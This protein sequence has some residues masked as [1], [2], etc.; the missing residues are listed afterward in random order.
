MQENDKHEFDTI[1]PAQGAQAQQKDV[2]LTLL[3]SLTSVL[4]SDVKM[5]S[6]NNTA[7]TTAS[8]PETTM[9]TTNNDDA[10]LL[11]VP[12]QPEAPTNSKVEEETTLAN[13]PA[14]TITTPS[15]QQEAAPESNNIIWMQQWTPKDVVPTETPNE[16]TTTTTNEEKEPQAKPETIVEAQ[17]QQL[18]AETTTTTTTTTMVDTIPQQPEDTTPQLTLVP[19]ITAEILTD[20]NFLEH[21][22]FTFFLN[23]FYGNDSR[24]VKLLKMCDQGCVVSYLSR[25]GELLAKQIPGYRTKDVRGSWNIFIKK[26]PNAYSFTHR[27][28]EHCVKTIDNVFLLTTFGFEWE[29]E[30][31]FDSLAMNHID[32]FETRLL[33]LD[34]TVTSPQLKNRPNFAQEMESEEAQFRQI[35]GSPKLRNC[36]VH[37]NPKKSTFYQCCVIYFS[38]EKHE[39]TDEE[40][41]GLITSAKSTANMQAT[42]AELSLW[43][44]FVQFLKSLVT[45]DKKTIA[46]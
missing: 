21:Q 35:F 34:T 43:A 6:E 46:S 23:K 2:L 19:I 13:E 33:K 36:T 38:A 3:S 30:I 17:P 29:V 26:Y 28:T 37:L 24:V 5:K 41:K 9:T 15:E 18:P 32:G 14:T 12:A 27:R 16:T 39:T 40:V 1:V 20:D 10:N 44:K 31:Y 11:S 22:A 7:A 4:N 8:N 42:Q 45:S 25:I